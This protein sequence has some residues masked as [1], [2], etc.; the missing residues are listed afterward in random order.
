MVSKAIEN[1][2]HIL[3]VTQ[4]CPLIG[5]ILNISLSTHQYSKFFFIFIITVQ[6][7][8]LLINI[9]HT[10]FVLKLI[11][12]TEQLFLNFVYNFVRVG[13]PSEQYNQPRC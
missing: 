3:K 12:F 11:I 1:L 2:F 5:S 9:M 10:S 7:V 6:Y 4:F 13:V 8:Q